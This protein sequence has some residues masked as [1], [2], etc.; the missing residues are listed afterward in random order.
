MPTKCHP[1][2]Q[3]ECYL[4]PPVVQTATLGDAIKV[5]RKDARFSSHMLDALEKVYAYSNATPQVRHG[6]AKA[7]RP[8][9]PE[10]ELAHAVGVAF[11]LYIIATVRADA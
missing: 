1:S 10:A 4:S 6:H 2:A 9:L 3:R 5:L 11:V 8:R 7:G